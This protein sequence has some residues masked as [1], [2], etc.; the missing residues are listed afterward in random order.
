[1]LL[2]H[3]T[4]EYVWRAHACEQ[5]CVRENVPLPPQP[6]IRYDG[7]ADSILS[8][9][10]TGRASCTLLMPN[11]WH[12]CTQTQPPASGGSVCCPFVLPM[13]SHRNLSRVFFPSL[14][15]NTQTD[16]QEGEKESTIKQARG[17]VCLGTCVEVRGHLESVLSCHH[18][19]SW[20]LNSGFQAYSQLSLPKS[21]GTSPL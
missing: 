8:D 5:E 15:K 3:A 12:I 19:V 1:M 6:Q 13:G 4:E 9:P 20:G 18:G 21:R 14:L 16:R 11:G 2:H 7:H 10:C 17:Y